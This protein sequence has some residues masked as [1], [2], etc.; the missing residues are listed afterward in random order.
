MEWPSDGPLLI[1]ILIF[2]V[3]TG[4]L[5]WLARRFKLGRWASK[6]FHLERENASQQLKINSL[7]WELDRERKE[8]AHLVEELE[9]V[10]RRVE[11]SRKRAEHIDSLLGPEDASDGPIPR[12]GPTPTSGASSPTPTTT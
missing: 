9:E 4:V 10:H 11:E 2:L 12:P 1:R 6:R 3:P 5:G 8:N 7:E